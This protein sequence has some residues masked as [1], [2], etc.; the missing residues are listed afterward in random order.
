MSTK[1]KVLGAVSKKTRK[2]IL[3]DFKKMK[4]DNWKYDLIAK[5]IHDKYCMNVST[6]CNIKNGKIIFECVSKAA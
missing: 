4:E 6:I 3:E 5:Y 2:E 1:I